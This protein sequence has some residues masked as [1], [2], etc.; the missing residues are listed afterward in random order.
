MYLARIH[1]KDR[2]KPLEVF[3]QNVGVRNVLAFLLVYL[4]FSIITVS[5]CYR[6]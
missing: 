4:E 2:A 5:K 3:R 6:I 1:V